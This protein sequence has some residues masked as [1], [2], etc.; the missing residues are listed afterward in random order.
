[1]DGIVIPDLRFE[2]SFLKRIDASA[3]GRSRLVV[4]LAILKDQV[5]MPFMQ[6]LLWLGLVLLARP[7]LVQVCAQGFHTG[8]SLKRFV[9]YS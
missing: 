3:G 7:F 8:L 4:T 1:M 9:G 6:G 5:L 2:Q